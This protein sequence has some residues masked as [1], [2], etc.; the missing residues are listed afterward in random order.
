MKKIYYLATSLLLI[1]IS[2]SSCTKKLEKS[3]LDEF[4]TRTFWNSEDNAFLALTAVYR[5][6]LNV[7]VS[8]ANPSDWWSSQGLHFL[9]MASDNAYHGQG[10]NSAYNKLSNGTLT[11]NLGLLSIFWSMSY[12]KI[13]R[14]NDFLQNIGR[15]P[16]DEGRKKRMIAEVRFLRA[17]QYFYLS[18]YFGSVPLVTKTLTPEEANTVH[19]TP[20]PELT[21]FVRA[22][23][24]AAAT[25]L[26]RFKQIPPSETGRACKQAVLAFL[27][28]AQLADGLFAEAASTYKT[29]IDLG[30]NIIDPDYQSIFLEANENSAENIFSVQFIPN[31]FANAMMQNTAPRAIGGFTFLNPLA[32][33]MEAYQFTDGTPFSYTDPRYDYNDIGKNRDPRLRYT[34]YY[35]RA[36]FRDGMYISHPDSTNSPDQIMKLNSRTGY[37]LKKYIDESITGNL[38]TDNG[39]NIPII[40]YAEVLL[41]YLEAKLEAGDAIDR[42]L[43]DATIN[44]VRGRASVHMPP[45]TETN[46]ALLR[47]LLR[48]E[49]R[50]ELALEGIRY[51]DLLRWKIAGQV[52]NGDFYG[53]PYPVSKTAIRKKSS[54][55]P[56][57][58]YKRWY[59]TT[60]KFR[61][62]IDE[63]WPIP[64]SEVDINPN[65]R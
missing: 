19:K 17:C 51:W 2:S 8:G 65:L 48:N 13:A 52:L 21:D 28:R 15:V 55:T 20:L 5:G 64:Q 47:P 43:L 26:P 11:A 1:I 33:L 4:D 30:E 31:V 25:D 10:E 46:P 27:G 36:P 58:P 23:F 14:C 54:S 59:V 42:A 45:I 12:E 37:L 60:R 7:N 34:I 56:A 16:M 57:D 32:S 3:P 39:G 44:K 61:V 24:S 6:G 40:R 41:S 38:R 63:H 62:G 29:I 22:E 35:N 53:H 49:R 50:V 9:D 18:Q